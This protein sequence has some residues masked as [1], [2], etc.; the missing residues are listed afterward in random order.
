MA[1][2]SKDNLTFENAVGRLETIVSQM[3]SAELP[4]DAIIEKYEEGMK[5]LAFCGEKLAAAE[6]KIELLTHDQAG[7]LQ[8]SALDAA[9]AADRDP[10]APPTGK[11]G[12]GD[13]SEISLF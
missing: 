7:N 11:A 4:L 3:E 2:A 5:L 12:G 9:K 13:A 8:R 1:K 6:K 10:A